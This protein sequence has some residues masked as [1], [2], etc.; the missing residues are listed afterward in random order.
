MAEKP[1]KKTRGP[2]YMMSPMMPV[3][4]STLDKD[5]SRTRAYNQM[6]EIVGPGRMERRRMG[7]SM[8]PGR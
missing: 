1:S 3:S 8:H 5:D 7:P 2:G 4:G 6:T